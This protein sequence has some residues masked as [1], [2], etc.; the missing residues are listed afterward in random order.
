TNNPSVSKINKSETPQTS[1]N[2]ASML[3]KSK[4]SQ[5]SDDNASKTVYPVIPTPPN[6]RPSQRTPNPNRRRNISV[7][8]VLQDDEYYTER[9]DFWTPLS[10]G[11]IERHIENE[12]YPDVNPGQAQEMLDQL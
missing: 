3:N 9:G 2:N 10:K 7:S 1:D 12:D 4:T 11:S 6:P 8:G 5:I